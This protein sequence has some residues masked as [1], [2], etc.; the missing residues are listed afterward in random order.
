MKTILDLYYSALQRLLTVLMA[1]LIVPVSMQVL[2]RYTGLVP[3]Y[4]WT[5]EVARFCFI[6]VVMVGSM[7]AVRD[8]THFDVDLLPHPKRRCL[9]VLSELFVHL[10]MLGFAIVFI[11]FGWDFVMFARYQES[12]IAELPLMWIYGAWPLAG[13]TWTLFLVEKVVD[14]VRR[15]RAGGPSVSEPQP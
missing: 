9:A 14:D 7:V 2:S 11:V 15:L 5:E 1:V 6:W 3:R 12:E 10:C 8:G 4:I 13:A